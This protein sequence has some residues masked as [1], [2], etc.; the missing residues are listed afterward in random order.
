MMALVAGD[1]LVC[2]IGSSCVALLLLVVDI[3][4]VDAGWM[5]V[6]S[7]LPTPSNAGSKVHQSTQ[8]YRSYRHVMINRC[9]YLYVGVQVGNRFLGVGAWRSTG[10]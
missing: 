6:N 3:L 9:Q 7:T 2:V 10:G 5:E 8:R 1:G 4:P